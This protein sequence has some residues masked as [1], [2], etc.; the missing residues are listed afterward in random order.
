[1]PLSQ[2]ACRIARRRVET[3]DPRHHLER[4]ISLQLTI[5]SAEKCMVTNSSYLAPRQPPPRP[6]TSG[7]LNLK[8]NTSLAVMADE[9]FQHI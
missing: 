4:G 9:N 5:T 3:T 2:L 7:P 6:R 1:M 8:E